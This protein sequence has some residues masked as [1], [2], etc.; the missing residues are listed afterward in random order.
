[1]KRRQRI[2]LASGSDRRKALLKQ[3]KIPFKAITP[4]VDETGVAG[5]SLTIQ[6]RI[7]AAAKVEA[8][9]SQVPARQRRWIVGMDT[10]ITLD[11]D[12]FGKPESREEAG[13]MLGRLAGKTHEV[14]TGLALLPGPE[15]KI[16]SDVCSSLVQFR[17]M[18]A[19]EIACYLD[20]GEWREAAGGYRIQ[21][22]GA[23]FVESI[24]GS[25]SN[26]VGLP[27]SLFYGML[28]GAGYVFT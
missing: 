27:L 21:Q 7:L 18:N 8:V 4:S 10:L 6:V 22:R 1:M 24:E 2:I 13:W 14:A 9:L 19:E 26:I 12:I 25:Y 3:V 5:E 20:T 15:E 17:A 28:R 16:R 11:G 23:F